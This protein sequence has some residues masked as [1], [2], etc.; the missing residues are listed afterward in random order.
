MASV[1]AIAGRFTITSHPPD[2]AMSFDGSEPAAPRPLQME[3]ATAEPV[4]AI[5]GGRIVTPSGTIEGGSVIIRGNRIDRVRTEPAPLADRV[6]DATDRV[7]VPGIVDVHGDD[8]EHQ[9]IPRTGARIDPQTA[10]VATDRH[11]VSSGITT[12]A[13]AIAFEDEQADHR[14][15]DGA[16]N[17]LQVLGSSAGFLGTNVAHVRFELSSVDPDTVADV[18]AHDTV[19]LASV[20]HHRPGE[21]QYE[22]EEDFYTRYAADAGLG[23]GSVEALAEART[24]AGDVWADTAPRIVESALA[25]GIPVASHDDDSAEAVDRADAYGME[26][27]EFPLTKAAAH[28]AAALG[29]T[30]VMGAPNLIRGESLFDN[31]KA[32]EAIDQGACDVL[33]A[34]YHPPSLLQSMFVETGEPLHER[35]SRVTESPARMLGMSDRGRIAAGAR[36]DLL[37][38]D[39]EPV[40][41]PTDV[42]VG[43]RRVLSQDPVAD[44]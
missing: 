6:V 27:C 37:V 28:R 14:S 13:H 11:N 2:R 39:P 3:Y 22:R 9:L 40:P 43:G 35:V 15:P 18:L 32:T 21:G 29:M 42:F 38:V 30:T 33:C 23:D 31:L 20:M 12:K 8:Y 17:L 25:E 44:Q 24:Q 36:A 4:T 26:I 16:G 10:F 1:L 7:V 5:E 41:R 34:D 19:V